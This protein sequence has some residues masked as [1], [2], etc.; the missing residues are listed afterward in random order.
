MTVDLS[1]LVAMGV[2]AATGV[3]LV[4]ERNLTRIMLGIMLLTNATILL[5]F[6]TSG[7]PG[8]APIREPGTDPA[9][10]ADPMPQVLILT[11]IV[12]GFATTAFLAAMIYRSWLLRRRDEIRE[13]IEDRRVAARSAWDAED[14]AELT[15]EHSEFMDDAADPNADYE[16][17]TERHPRARRAASAR[18]VAGESSRRPEAGDGGE[19]A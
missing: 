13:D 8:L 10:Y 15:E 5:L 7:G 11:A 12:I 2:L 1:L 9:D 6:L 3:Y 4:L 18:R 19:P 17:A 14:D 16:R